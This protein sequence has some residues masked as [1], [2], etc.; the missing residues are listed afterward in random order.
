LRVVFVQYGNNIACAEMMVASCKKLGYE[1]WQ[2]SD[3]SAPEVRGVDR[4]ERTPMTEGRMIYRTRRLAEVEAPYVLLDTD[5]IVAQDISDGFSPIHDVSLSW[6]AKHMVLSKDEKEPLRM[7]YNG[8]VIFVRSR[9]FM[10]DCLIRMAAME[11]KRQDW[12]GDQIA[13]RDAAESG[14]YEV[15]ELR[16][17]AWN[18]CP[19]SMG[20]EIPNVRIYHFKGNRKALMPARFKALYG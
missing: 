7:P 11:P 9:S 18:F 5:M 1:V 10:V 4:L 14:L 16:D 17:E 8:G 2:L 15:K 13:L 6:R 20:H 12:Y 3:M 19:D